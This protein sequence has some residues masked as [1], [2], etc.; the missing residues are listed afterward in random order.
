MVVASIFM[1]K[2][3]GQAGA[4][5]KAKTDAKTD[6]KKNGTKKTDVNTDSNNLPVQC[7][8]RNKKPPLAKG[9]I[10]IRFNQAGKLIGKL[11]EE[12]VDKEQIC[13]NVMGKNG[14]LVDVLEKKRKQAYLHLVA[15]KNNTADPTLSSIYSKVF[16]INIGAY[17]NVQSITVPDKVSGDSLQY[18]VKFQDGLCNTCNDCKPKSYDI[19]TS[20]FTIKD[21]DIVVDYIENG[22]PAEDIIHIGN[23]L[24][25]TL[26]K[27]DLYKKLILSQLPK[28]MED[29]M[30]WHNYK[31]L[32]D[33]SKVLYAKARDLYKKEIKFL[34]EA[35]T[36]NE[37][38][39][40]DERKAK[41][42]ELIKQDTS[43]ISQEK[44][45]TSY[46]G[47][48]KNIYPE[49][50]S[51]WL[52]YTGGIPLTNP[53]N[54]KDP[55]YF[56]EP[57]TSALPA[58]RFRL[59]VYQDE[60]KHENRE[61]T[62]RLIDTIT[63][64]IN[65]I[66]GA[67]NSYKKSVAKNDT[68]IKNFSTTAYNMNNSF[69]YTSCCTLYWM[70]HHDASNKEQMLDATGLDEYLESDRI[71][72]LNHNL[73]KDQVANLSLTA[74]PIKTDF[75]TA[76]EELNMDT[77][78]AKM[79]A[80]NI[81]I[82]WKDFSAQSYIKSLIEPQ[83]NEDKLKEIIKLLQ[84]SVDA[85]SK[86]IRTLSILNG[87]TAPLVGLEER[88][89]E[90]PVYHTELANNSGK[91][92]G[93]LTVNYHFN[94]GKA[95]TSSSKKDTATNAP[96]VFAYRVD[97]LYRIFPFVGYAMLTN[98][99]QILTLNGTGTAP[100]KLTY[101]RLS[102]GYVGLKLYFNKTNIRS[103]YIFGT[104]EHNPKGSCLSI[105]AGVSVPSPL[106]VFFTGLGLDL[107][108]GF[109]LNCGVSFRSYTWDSFLSSQYVVEHDTYR[110]GF[111]VGLTTDPAFA[112]E[113]AKLL[114]F[115]K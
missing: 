18:R 60:Y 28:K 88:S 54:F 107:W 37:T 41:G 55:K 103:K 62:F 65:K 111:Y 22:S 1:L 82:N 58:L 85:L 59:S 98:P 16:G 86:A 46:L 105:D 93:P 7:D 83:A 104:G 17:T 72:I 79:L 84:S 106:N 44:A 110:P 74:I 99:V 75:T 8:C 20:K 40:D 49:W 36:L 61:S 56:T 112:A 21:K 57:D 87:Q 34:D 10:V 89:E 24:E 19:C 2:A 35:K 26:V 102:T 77:L 42:D 70:R 9:T 81:A 11:P 108:P 114:N 25:F 12:L 31:L 6:T 67:F 43:A 63:K 91:F 71:M 92:K 5:D 94:D 53:F 68:A 69:L 64:Q 50:V 113:L 76:D 100:T 29:T 13:F 90:S 101:S 33:T 95:V 109:T 4:E 23:K 115:S 47:G 32:L 45:L 52:W 27:V 51:K 48:I 3:W 66:Q 78:Q 14:A 97:K 30:G 15:V 80:S 39:K 38:L 73:L 96:F